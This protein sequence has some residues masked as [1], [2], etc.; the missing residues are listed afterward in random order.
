MPPQKDI[1]LLKLCAKEVETVEHI[2]CD[3]DTLPR[4]IY[5]SSSTGQFEPPTITR[6]AYNHKISSMLRC[7]MVRITII[8]ISCLNVD[9]KDRYRENM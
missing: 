5:L 7:I 2:L 9:F 6:L 1:D 3:C 8:V 4:K